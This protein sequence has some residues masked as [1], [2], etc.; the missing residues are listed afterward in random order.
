METIIK[1]DEAKIKDKV[2]NDQFGMQV[3]RE[4]KRLIDKF[5]P[6]KTNMLI[7][8]YQL[9]PF[10]IWY[11]ENHSHYI[12]MGE[13]Y[14]DPDYGVG[15]FYSPGYGFWSRPGVKKIPS[16]QKL[17]F[18]GQGT[19]HWDEKAAKAGQLNK[20]YRTLNNGLQSGHF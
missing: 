10:A 4:W 20:L 7:Q 9:L 3:S 18:E 11:K 15:A 13:K 14:I 12:Y 2:T 8:N 6:R 1:L 16:G 17:E 5:T 19:D